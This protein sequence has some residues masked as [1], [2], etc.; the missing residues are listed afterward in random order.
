MKR[1][2]YGKQH[3]D[4]GDIQAVK[5]VLN[6]EWL[7]QGPGVKHFEKALA[8]YCGAKYAVAVS[9]GTAALHIACLAAGLKKGDEAITTPITFLA[10]P[11]SVIYTGATPVFA[12]IDYRT[13]NID[14]E[15]IAFKIT[16]KTKAVLPVHFAGLPADMPKIHKLAKKK[17]L[18]VI[19]DA[20]HALG[21]EYKYRNR[22]IKV[23]SCKHS[24]M[25][26]FSFHPVKAITTGEGGAVLT[27]SR[28]LYNKLCALRS[29]GTY[30]DERTFKKGAWVYEMRDIGFNYR[31]T[32]I[33]SAL[34]THQLEKIG[35]FLSK[36]EKISRL[37]DEA[38]SGMEEIISGQSFSDSSRKHA[39]HLYL[40]RV[41][42]NKVKYR[43]KDIFDK[44]ISRGIG[45]QI[46]YIPIYKQP[47]YIRKG[48]K[49]VICSNAEKYYQEAFSLPLYPDLNI[50]DVKRVIKTVKEILKE[51]K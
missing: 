23:G 46:H 33:Q 36:R 29:H 35:T 25:S 48:Y 1:I 42:K 11:N 15:E 49:N 31:I 50:S 4:P 5:E 28:D 10:T 8:E 22:W 38:F 14:P 32:D 43:K 41:N 26:V 9:S 19:E 39:R 51:A 2:P 13:V 3:I 45:V 20:C 16:G 47:F 24:D 6:S 21:S 7:T 17:K 12:D 18:I 27:N 37:Y 30:K 44:F 34:G 40:L